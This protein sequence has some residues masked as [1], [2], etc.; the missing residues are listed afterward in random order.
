M[1]AVY[2]VLLII[3]ALLL[4]PYLVA[5]RIRNLL[6]HYPRS[7]G[8]QRMVENSRRYLM[9][10]LP[11][12]LQN[13]LAV[14]LPGAGSR[15]RQSMAEAA[16]FYRSK[17]FDIAWVDYPD[18]SLREGPLGWGLPE[19]RELVA[20]L[21][22]V[23][24]PVVVHGK[25]FG[26]AVALIAHA[27]SPK[28][29]TTV[30]ESAY[31]SLSEVLEYRTLRPRWLPR[32]ILTILK[33]GIRE[34]EKALKAWRIDVAANAPLKY[35]RPKRGAMIFLHGTDDRLIPPRHSLLL[36]KQASWQG[37]PAELILIEGGRHSNLRSA[38][39]SRWESALE[40]AVNQACGKS[41]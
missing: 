34:A 13:P 14:L 36:Y 21:L 20:K 19:A 2:S 3:L 41:S 16:D 9:V 24:V 32:S 5:L 37:I 10:D 11:S 12:P 8:Y 6:L 38:D 25:S 27:L 17:G 4:L 29:W 18:T 28:E 31:T 33:Q 35:L 26:A 23:R 22:T 1:T 39:V 30:S 7:A 40:W 15:A